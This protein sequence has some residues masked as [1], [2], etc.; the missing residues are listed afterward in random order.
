MKLDGLIEL[1]QWRKITLKKSP[2]YEVTRTVWNKWYTE[3]REIK[4]MKYLHIALIEDNYGYRI[5][6]KDY[7]T[8]LEILESDNKKE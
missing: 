5:N 1:A 4:F 8:L 3:Q 7:A 6:K 2:L